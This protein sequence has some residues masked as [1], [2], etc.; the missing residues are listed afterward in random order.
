MEEELDVMEEEE[1][2]QD[3]EDEEE[4]NWRVFDG[5]LK[6]VRNTL[7]FTNNE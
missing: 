3:E 6:K 2:M 7:I 5:V 1:V 4:D